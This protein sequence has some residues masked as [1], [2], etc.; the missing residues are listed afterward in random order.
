MFVTKATSSILVAGIAFTLLGLAAPA[1]V[2]ADVVDCLAEPTPGEPAPEPGE[3]V[4]M[5]QEARHDAEARI[6]CVRDEVE[7]EII[8]FHGVGWASHCT[9]GSGLL[10]EGC[11]DDVGSLEGTK[12][13]VTRDVS[14]VF[15]GLL[16]TVS[17]QGSGGS[18]IVLGMAAGE[19]PCWAD[20][21]PQDL[22]CYAWMYVET[23]AVSSWVNGQGVCT[24]SE[25]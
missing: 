12:D 20:I 5:A 14:L 23:D 21:D 24:A 19:G 7:V 15:K 4:A 11:Y 18:T 8:T 17:C 22:E 1:A 3:I 25:F 13:T 10:P 6:Q 16:G 2:Q 9:D